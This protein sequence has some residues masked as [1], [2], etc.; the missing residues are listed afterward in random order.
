MDDKQRWKY[1]YLY[2][3][4]AL[5]NLTCSHFRFL[6][7]YTIPRYVPPTNQPPHASPLRLFTSS[8]RTHPVR[9]GPSPVGSDRFGLHYAFPGPGAYPCPA[10]YRSTYG[11]PRSTCS[12]ISQIPV[13]DR[14]HRQ[15]SK[16]DQALHLSLFRR[17]DCY[18]EFGHTLCDPHNAPRSCHP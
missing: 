9:C 4:S 18:Y 6:I 8:S 14:R 3:S 10:C 1:V 12:Q 17:G 2:F 15:L 7:S 13:D 16:Q 11:S 5:V